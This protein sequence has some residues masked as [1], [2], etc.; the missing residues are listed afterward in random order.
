MRDKILHIL[1][2]NQTEYISG[3][4]LSRRLGVSRTAIWKSINQ[5]K[6]IGYKIT[7]QT[8]KGY[9]L[10]ESP[11][12]LSEQEIRPLLTGDIV[13]SNIAY[14][15]SL[16]STNTYAKKLAEQTFQEGLVI[17]AEEQTAGRGRMG[18]SW[19]S[20]KGK[21]IWMSILLKPDV[22]PRDASKLTLVAATAVCR[23]IESCCGL[24]PLI[25]WP[26][27]IVMEGRKLCGIL[28]EMGA[29]MDD[30]EYVVVGIG[31]NA[32]L[33]EA[34]F[35]EA[36]RP[37]ATS[38]RLLQGENILRK[39][40]VAAI[41][42]EFNQLY[43]PFRSS[44]SIGHMLEEYKGKSAVIG[45]TVRILGKNQDITAKAVDI[46]PE[47]HLIIET[48]DGNQVTVN[49]GEISVRGIYGYI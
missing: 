30:I 34:D 28:T 41:L 18:R 15:E 44:G 36:V 2:E 42:N 37:I 49:S 32:N 31:I 8:N 48:S 7:S 43:H 40:L 13:G 33:E 20:P 5:L 4:E 24:K 45:N 1:K 14:F 17:I 12:A 11:D 9:L 38:L 10:I 25:K 22:R 6:E 47:G 46:N 16:E 3:E 35:D 29:E 39:K 27:D 21:G 23:G 26:N 19:I